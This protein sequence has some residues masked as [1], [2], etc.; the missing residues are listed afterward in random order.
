MTD[1]G[2][3][4]AACLLVASLLGGCATLG[5][6]PVAVGPE[7]AAPDTP[8]AEREFR[9]AWV[10]TVVNIDWPSRPGLAIPDQQAEARA[11]LDAAVRVQLNA[12]VLQV[13]PHADALYPSDLE[14]W[15]VYLTG[16]AG[17]APEPFYDPLAFWIEEAHDRGLELHAWLNPYRAHM[18]K[19]GPV[20][21]SSIVNREP[22]L[23]RKLEN[24]GY[25]LDPGKRETQDHSYEVVLDIVRRYD[26]DGIHFDD[27]F[28][29]YGDGSF[30]DD[31]TYAAYRSEG[32]ALSR[33]DFRRASVDGFVK[34]VSSGIKK[35][36]PHVKFGISPFGIWRPGH[37]PSIEGFDPYDGLYADS[38]RWLREGWVDYLSPQLYWPVNQ[39]PQSFP[40]LLGW[41]VRENVRG[42]HLWPGMIIGKRTD[43]KGADEIVNQIMIARG[44]VPDAPGHIHFSM[45]T[46]L[47]DDTALAAAL[48]DGPYR[49]PSLVPPSA[50]L[51]A[52]PPAAPSLSATADGDALRVAWAHAAPADVFRWVVTA[53]YETGSRI[54]ILGRRDRSVRIP[55]SRSRKPRAKGGDGLE[56]GS[57]AID[58][59]TWIAV[60]AVDRLGNESER[61]WQDVRG[62]ARKEPVFDVNGKTGEE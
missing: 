28:Y 4:P 46:L 41:W 32:G 55:L 36:K 33:P 59:L 58:R 26:V 17:Q 45:K 29:P 57:D 23:A 49:S 30:P 22:G 54:V 48:R 15:S 24:G 13:R 42:R 38:R 34:R 27:Y 16:V 6:T 50:W 44:L 31:E 7:G 53:R 20:P 11:L 25:W 56:A 5:P 3:R 18:P 35:A 51:E 10:A 8:R 37:P 62:A 14:P 47:K 52:M 60:S 12:I 40:V 2:T 9:A 61:A 39:I 1:H 21:E 43:E 19:G